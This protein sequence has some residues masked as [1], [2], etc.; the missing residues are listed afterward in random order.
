MIRAVVA[1]AAGRMGG[2]NLRAV[3]EADDFELCGAFEVAGHA[4]VGKDEIGRA[5]V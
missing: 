2:C 4:A 3:R 5:H 1:G